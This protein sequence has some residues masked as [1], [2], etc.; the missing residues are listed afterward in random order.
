MSD[1][2]PPSKD[3]LLVSARREMTIALIMWA[4]AALCT[5]GVVSVW[6]YDRDPKSL[7]FVLGFPD[8]VFWGIIV[9]WASSTIL[10]SI[11]AMTYMQDAPLEPDEPPPPA[12]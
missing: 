1:L 5:L 9:P 11:F 12:D 3:P 2:A 4:V 6:G 8:W 7:T 10:A